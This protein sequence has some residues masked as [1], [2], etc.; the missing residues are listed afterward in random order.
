MKSANG[1]SRWLFQGLSTRGLCEPHLARSIIYRNLLF[2]LSLWYWPILWLSNWVDIWLSIM[3]WSTVM[4]GVLYVI[5]SLSG[6]Y[7]FRRKKLSILFPIFAA[8]SG[9]LNGFVGGC[10]IG[11]LLLWSPLFEH[12]RCSCRS[13]SSQF[14][15][16]VNMDSISMGCPSY[17]LS[18]YR[19]ILNHVFIAVK[20]DFVTMPYTHTH[21]LYVF[22]SQ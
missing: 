14:Y 7:A 20:I 4:C 9:A 19:F 8:I 5:A 10:I 2:I 18:H 21:I 16:Y 15:T 12:R 1:P 3:L 13:L 6:V 22:S 11:T 17:S